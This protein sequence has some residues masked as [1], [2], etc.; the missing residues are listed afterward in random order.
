MFRRFSVNFGVISMFLDGFIIGGSLAVARLIRPML[1]DLPAFKYAGEVVVF[2]FW[3]YLVFPLIWIA[4]FLGGAIYDGRRYLSRSEELAAF[5]LASGLAVIASAGVLY[6]SFREL[7]RALFLLHVLIALFLLAGWRAIFGWVRDRWLGESRIRRV[8]IIGEGSAADEI[9][10]KILSSNGFNL[11]YVGTL[12]AV[13]GEGLLG[14]YSG[15]VEIVSKEKI[16]HVVI[17]LPRAEYLLVNGI[18]ESLVEIPV[19]IWVVPDYY[20]LALYEARTSDYAGITLLDLRAPAISD[21]QRMVKRAFDLFGSILLL[22]LSLPLMVLIALLLW[23]FDPGPLIYNSPRAGENGKLFR[24]HKFRT[25]VSDADKLKSPAD[26]NHKERGD[27][28]ITPIGKFLR[29]TSLDEI[30]Q[31][32]NV[33]KGEMSLVGPRPELP[34]LVEKYEGWQRQRFSVPPGVTG[35]W[36]V[37]GRS[38][39]PMHLH[40]E[41]DLFYIKNYSLWLDIQILVRTIWVVLIGR[42]AY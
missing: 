7:S 35:W 31:L 8:L 4:V 27:P 41:D 5:S 21:Y 22:P 17:A 24:M 2:P 13:A 23:I 38:D 37:N 3:L 34:E 12:G 39:R 6:L 28:R 9:R 19:R 26:G 11:A 32:F 14:N 25:M 29:K 30:P 20:S 42:G 18:V 1:N 16:D 10:E 15:V 40:T 36:Q 33:I